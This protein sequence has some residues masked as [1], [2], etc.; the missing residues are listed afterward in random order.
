MHCGSLSL[1]YLPETC[2]HNF[3]SIRLDYVVQGTPHGGLVLG[4]IGIDFIRNYADRFHHAK[5]ED[6]LF[7]ALVDN[8]TP[9]EN[10]PVAAM[11]MELLCGWS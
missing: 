8:G 4:S 11:L 1:L 10:S 2:H 5:E 7:K 6:V 9:K 3:E